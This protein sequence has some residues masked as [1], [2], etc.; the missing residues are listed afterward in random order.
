MHKNVAQSEKITYNYN[1]IKNGDIMN[2]LIRFKV[3]NFLSINDT[4]E[5]SMI[6]SKVRGKRE[7]L[8][9]NRG[10]NLL[11]FSRCV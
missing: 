8:S 5:L 10:M 6:S 1:I 3:S 7:H 2:M 9:L 4:Q 11:R